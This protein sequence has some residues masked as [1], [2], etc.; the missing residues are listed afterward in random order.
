MGEEGGPGTN[1]LQ[2]LR[3]NRTVSIV[4]PILHSLFAPYR[5]S[6]GAIQNEVF[7]RTIKEYIQIIY[8]WWN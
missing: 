8:I 7:L 2:I 3:D 4:Q 5:L 1:P 6:K